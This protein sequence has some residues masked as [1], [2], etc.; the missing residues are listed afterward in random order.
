MEGDGGYIIMPKLKVKDPTLMPKPM[1]PGTGDLLSQHGQQKKPRTAAI[2]PI[3]F[4]FLST[5]LSLS[6]AAE[7]KKAMRNFSEGLG[8]HFVHQFHASASG[9]LQVHLPK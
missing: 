1:D 6:I 7:V 3:H 8:G 9:H 5:G 4:V 2:F